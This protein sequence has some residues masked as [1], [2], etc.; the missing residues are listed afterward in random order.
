MLLA[1]HILPRRRTHEHNDELSWSLAGAWV[2]FRGV[3]ALAT[4]VPV[5]VLRFGGIPGDQNLNLREVA[6]QQFCSR[7]G[8]AP[9]SAGDRFGYNNP[10]QLW[11]YATLISSMPWPVT[12]VDI[13]LR[14]V[15][16]RQSAYLVSRPKQTR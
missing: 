4:G 5:G 10:T 15:L 8:M 14:P 12:V 16:V 11:L 7:A 9:S 1:Q 2:A 6:R 3:A 13:R